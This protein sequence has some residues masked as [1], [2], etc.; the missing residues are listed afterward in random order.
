MLE[1]PERVRER[2]KLY[3]QL[4][5]DADLFY[6]Y[7]SKPIKHTIRVNTLKIGVGEL[8]KR[9]EEKGFRLRGVPWSDWFYNVLESPTEHP[10]RTL[11]HTLGYYYV[12]EVVSALPPLVLDP[13]PGDLVLDL[14][15]APGSKT[16]Q[17]AQMMGNKGTIIANDIDLERLSALRSNLERLGVTNTVVVRSDARTIRLDLRFPKILVD[18][19]CSSEG[20]VR[21]DPRQLASLSVYTI[22]RLSR[23]QK[24]IVRRAA[25]LLDKEGV[26]VY[27]VCTFAPEEAEEV[28]SYAIS[29]GLEPEDVR[30]PVKSVNGVR[31]WV[32]EKGRR[33]RYHPGVEKAVRVYPHDDYTGGMFIAKLRKP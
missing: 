22:T 25:E 23:L 24:S 30:L 2:F 29:L 5:D 9:L 12:Q 18:A 28:V 14:T 17:M 31:E 10:G 33:H 7:V 19:P 15:A 26:L 21:K 3:R 20:T 4:V 8:V 16:S 1:L 32:D 27:S 13:G 11:E 6:H